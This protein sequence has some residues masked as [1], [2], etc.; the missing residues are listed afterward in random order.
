[1]TLI[2][3]RQLRT[4]TTITVP[5]AA[6]VLIAASGLL[7]AVQSGAWGKE[8][9]LAAAAT[10]LKGVPL[11]VGAWHAKEL[12]MEPS[13]LKT[14]QASGAWSRVY[15]KTGDGERVNVMMLCGPSGPIAVHP[16]TV[17]FTAAGY[18]QVTD[19]RR[20]DVRDASGKSIG[21]FW[22][23]DFEWPRPTGSVDRIRTYW[24][25]SNDGKWRAPDYPRYQFAGSPVLNKLYVIRNVNRGDSEAELIDS[26]LRDFLPVANETVFGSKA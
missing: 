24:A 6:A 12:G 17:C 13:Q 20:V 16:P 19:Q 8:E 1:M 25:W 11:E 10:S 26:F 3:I 21:S 15:T 18:R 9:R 7:H 14:A 2:E 5:V 23:A 22:C 4:P